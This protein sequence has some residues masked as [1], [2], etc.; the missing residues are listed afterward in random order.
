M[1]LGGPST[2]ADFLTDSGSPAAV[3]VHDVSIVPAA[4]VIHERIP[5]CPVQPQPHK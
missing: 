2:V 5:A 4:A 1:L 3:E